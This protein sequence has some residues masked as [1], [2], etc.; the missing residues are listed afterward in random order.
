[1][2]DLK[3]KHIKGLIKLNGRVS[4]HDDDYGNSFCPTVADFERS[5]DEYVVGIEAEGYTLRIHIKREI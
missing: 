2:E 1:M 5:G 3:L 4:I